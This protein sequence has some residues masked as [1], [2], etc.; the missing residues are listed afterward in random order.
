MYKVKNWNVICILLF[1]SV[2]YGLLSLANHYFFRTYAFDLG[3]FNQAAFDYSKFEVNNNTVLYPPFP[4]LFGDHLCLI[5]SI[6][7]P[8]RYIFG[9]Y[10][11][12]IVQIA[13]ILFGGLGCYKLIFS[14]N[15][16]K[17]VATLGLIHFLTLWP[18]YSALSFDY[19]N[20]VVGVMMIPWFMYY[21]RSN[22][23]KLATIFALLLV[24]SKENMAMYMGVIAIGMAIKNYKN[25]KQLLYLSSLAVFCL[26]Y[27]AIAIKFIIP[28]LLPDGSTYKHFNYD[29]LG[30]D[31]GE[32]IVNVTR[33]PLKYLKYLFINHTEDPLGVN[34]KKDFYVF[35]I[36]G[37]GFAAILYP[38]YLIIV[39]FILAQ[40]MYNNAIEKWSIHY[41]YSIE[42]APIMTIALFELFSQ[43]KKR[44]TMVTLSIVA[45]VIS[46]F[47]SFNMIEHK[48]G[49]WFDKNRIQ[50]YNANHYNNN[51]DV[52]KLHEL[53][54]QIPKSAAVSTEFNILPHLAMREEC[55]QFPIVENA[56][57]I[58]CI[59]GDNYSYPLSNQNFL[60]EVEKYRVSAEWEI[61]YEDKDLLLLSKKH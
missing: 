54:N 52:V 58:L 20:H 9:S 35:F 18:I 40:K 4:N 32:S 47:L 46:G 3:I 17:T 37:G 39:L 34:V 60:K 29:A 55:Y 38:R 43:L 36:L 22:N 50:F 25:R 19:H 53:I 5:L 12:L 13:S 16:D 28:S 33:Y 23:Y 15:N 57:Y 24:I 44:V 8:L 21:L 59:I 61:S 26:V 48:S 51:F 49:N 45:I 2:I 27:F 14:F 6:I 30:R 11:L 56:E 7:S 42:L 1:F 10:T 31:F 41:Q